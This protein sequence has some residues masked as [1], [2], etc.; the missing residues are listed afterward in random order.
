MSLTLY[1]LRHGQTNHSR[2]ND[3]CGSLE[4]DLTPDGHT[5]AREF[6]AAYKAVPWAAVYCSP[7]R[8]AI[9]TANPPILAVVLPAG[10]SRSSSV[11]VA[12]PETSSV[13]QRRTNRWRSRRPPRA[14]VV[15]G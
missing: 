2:E 7:K 5:M 8:R 6:A 13:P 9:A 15:G 12:W 14:K 10:C 4:A 1:L 11:S 3:F